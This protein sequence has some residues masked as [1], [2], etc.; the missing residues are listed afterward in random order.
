MSRRT[1]LE[2]LI[3]P[4]ESED[5]PQRELD[6]ARIVE[7]AR[8]L[9]KQWPAK[10]SVGRP[11]LNSIEQTEKLGAESEAHWF[12]DWGKL[13][14]R[15]IPV[16][17]ALRPERRIDARLASKSKRAW[18]SKT[19]RIDYRSPGYRAADDRTANRFLA[20]SHYIRTDS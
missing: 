9:A 13:R 10:G 12:M 14:N 2:R 5:C 17:D 19:C 20:A 1:C 4:A 11:K 3:L 8:D 15:N 18:S 16:A 6:L 7:L